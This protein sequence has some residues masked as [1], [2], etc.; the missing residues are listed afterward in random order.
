MRKTLLSPS[1]APSHAAVPTMAQNA[2]TTRIKGD[3]K[4]VFFID[5][6]SIRLSGKAGQAASESWGSLRAGSS[7]CLWQRSDFTHAEFFSGFPERAQYSL[8]VLKMRRKDLLDHAMRQFRDQPVQHD[9]RIAFF[10]CEPR[11]VKVVGVPG[12]SKQPAGVTQESGK[13]LHVQ[14]FQSI[15]LC[16]SRMRNAEI[17]REALHP[18]F[19]GEPASQGVKLL[20]G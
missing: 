15:A 11:P 12:L 13:R 19:V 17:L 4:T 6:S 20:A 8:P 7:N 3:R 1:C 14:Q 2:R 18:D 16:E 9:G 5:H 10:I